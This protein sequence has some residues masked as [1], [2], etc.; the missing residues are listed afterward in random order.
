[1]TTQEGINEV[2]RATS[3]TATAT[4]RQKRTDSIIVDKLNVAMREFLRRTKAIK[5][6]ATLT[7]V[8]ETATVT[9]PS[10]FICLDPDDIVGGYGGV[11]LNS[12]PLK[13]TSI[14][15]LDGLESGWRSASSGIPGKW[16]FKDMN[17]I[18][19]HQKPDA[20]AA[21]YTCLLR[22]V[23]AAT[24]LS[25]GSLGASLLDG[26]Y[27]LIP[28]HHLLPYHAIAICAKEDGVQEVGDRFTALWEAGMEKAE[29]DIKALFSTR[30]GFRADP[31][32]VA[33]QSRPPC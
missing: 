16:A 1:M 6:E 2:R 17:T 12:N 23:K 10:D 4:A 9:V 8:A 13:H 31:S 30:G 29:K 18:L 24:A 5:T 28:Y 19:F 26:V 7:L 14:G 21:A 33:Q 22:H 3:D 11:I 32:F 27:G 20:T 15:L 25:S